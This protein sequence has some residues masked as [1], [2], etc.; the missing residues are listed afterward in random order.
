VA[1]STGKSRTSGSSPSIKS[2]GKSQRKETPKPVADG[3][4]ILAVLLAAA[5]VFGFYP[6]A[7][8]WAIEGV[9]KNKREKKMDVHEDKVK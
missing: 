3:L 5:A 2:S 6:G 7:R 8:V 4:I 1:R 9:T